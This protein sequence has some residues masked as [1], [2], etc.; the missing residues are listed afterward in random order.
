VA[1][2]FFGQFREP[3]QKTLV[4]ATLAALVGVAG[5]A[6]AAD[7]Y[8]PSASGYKDVVVVAPTWT[9]F[10]LGGHVGAGFSDAKFQDGYMGQPL[11]NNG[12]LSNDGVFGGAQLGYNIQHD[13]FLFG[14]E[15]DIG[16]LD[17]TSDRTVIH[18]DIARYNA[19]SGLYG[20]ITGRFGLVVGPALFYAKG[21]AAF[22]DGDFHN[23]YFS[24]TPSQYTNGK[25][26]TLWGWAV[27]GGLEYALN[28]AW[29]LKAEYQ[30]F[31]FGN[32][33]YDNSINA[34]WHNKFATTVE[35]VS[36][37]LNYHFGHGYDPLK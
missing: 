3:M 22:L 18:N 24:G 19:S 32:T 10:Y 4:A 12:T 25:S 15:G 11:Y 1:F 21:G 5:A 31:D 14:V 26:D 16:G 29:S 35:T 37:G 34:T 7:I 23:T 6:N 20:D 33:T 36:A 17:I 8:A 9:G 30:H 28:P 2:A 27:G 13:R